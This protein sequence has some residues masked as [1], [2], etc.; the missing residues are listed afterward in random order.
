[1]EIIAKKMKANLILI[2]EVSIS[3]YLQANLAGFN[4]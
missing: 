4:V 3:G 2:E 1:M